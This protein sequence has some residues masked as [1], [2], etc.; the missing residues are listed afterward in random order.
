MF[1]KRMVTSHSKILWIAMLVLAILLTACGGSAVPDTDTSTITTNANAVSYIAH[2][3]DA[4]DSARIGIVVEDGK[5]AVYICSLDDPFNTVAAR[6]YSG[7]VGAN[8]A[9]SGV[10]PDGVKFEGT[11]SGDQFT[12]VITGAA[13][14][15]W[16]F[17]GS[18]VPAGG[19][20]GLYR[21]I[22]EYGG[23]EIVVGAVVD[24]DGTFAS[25]VQVR[26]KIE[27]VTPVA[28]AP[29]RVDNDTIKVTLG[30]PSQQFEVT[31]VVTLKGVELF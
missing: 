3:D 24:P 2:I 20:A 8:G 22:G 16:N 28:G 13:G 11:V 26:G 21:G 18:A 19:P 30:D 12:G 6:W 23:Q 25:T 15:L 10:S 27:F 29:L 17:S 14:K 31:L 7:E 9:V 4:P 5:F 1:A